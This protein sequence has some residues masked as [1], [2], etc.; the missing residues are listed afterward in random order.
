MSRTSPQPWLLLLAVASSCAAYLDPEDFRLP[1]SP[2]DLTAPP[3]HAPR[4]SRDPESGAIVARWTVLV[5][6]DGRVVKDGREEHFG[7]DGSRTELRH[8]MEG[9]PTG[10]WHRW[11]EDGSLRSSYEYVP[12]VATSMR[13]FHP[14]G[15]PSAAGLAVEGKREGGWTFWYP[16]G[17]VRQE[18][19]YRAGLREGVWTLRW[20]G[21]GLRSRG[22]YRED[23]RVGDWKH[24]PEHP[25]TL[26]SA[27]SPPDPVSS[28]G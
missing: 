2:T 16:D 7:G 22:A 5:Y 28:G 26:E 12:G 1:A 4:S 25:I 11:Y 24:W 17:V 18:G 19:P 6:P 27:W 20:P 13:F 21:G 9:R 15:R 23:E 10:E 3:V 8:F 14:G